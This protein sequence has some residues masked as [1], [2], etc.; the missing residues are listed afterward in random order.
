MNDVLVPE[1][2]ID[3]IIGEEYEVHDE[4]YRKL[5]NDKKN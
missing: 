1:Y 4:E 2:K 5:K 3:W